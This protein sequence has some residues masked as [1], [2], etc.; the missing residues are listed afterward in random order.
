[1]KSKLFIIF[2]L[3][4]TIL[5]GTLVS[6]IQSEK[7]AQIVK[8]YAFQKIPESYGI[9]GDFSDF[10][11]KLFPPGVS[12]RNPKVTLEK[13]NILNFPENS[14]VEAKKVDLNFYPLQMISG[15]INVHEVVISGGNV[16]LSIH[17]DQL[18]SQKRKKEEKKQI[19][20]Q[21][22]FEVKLESV[23]LEGTSVHFNWLEPNIKSEFHSEYLK[24][25]K[26]DTDDGPG[27]VFDLDL[28]KIEAD[29]P[30]NWD[31]PNSVK[32]LKAFLEIS[33]KKV[34]IYNVS[35]TLEDILIQSRGH[36]Y[37]NVLGQKNLDLDV[38]I[39]MSGN[40]RKITEMFNV[41]ENLAGIALFK[42]KAKGN[43]F[44]L[45][46]TFFFSGEVE[47]TGVR[48]NQWET[49]KL[50]AKGE[51]KLSDKMIDVKEA[52]FESNHR[53]RKGGFQTGLGG[54][55]DFNSFQIRTGQLE[56]IKVPI[57]LT[58]AHLH[59][60]AAP[61]IVDVFPM[62]VRLS[63]SVLVE[64]NNFFSKKDWSVVSY[65]D[66]DIKNFILDNQKYQKNK[67]IS[68]ILN[69]PELKLK[70]GAEFNKNGFYPKELKIVMPNTEL[71]VGGSVT[72]KNG[73]DLKAN[74]NV[75]FADFDTLAKNKIRGVGPLQIHVHG[76]TYKV[77]LDFDTNLQNTSYL[78]L[79]IGELIGR[80]TF[81]DS[82]QNLIFND[83]KVR[84]NKLFMDIGGRLNV[85]AQDFADLKVKS[86]SGEVNDLIKMFN[87]LVKDIDWFPESLSGFIRGEAVVTGQLGMDQIAIIGKFTGSNWDFYGEKFRELNFAGGY[88]QGK[89]FLQNAIVQKR[90]GYF[91]GD[92]S[93]SE[94]KGVDWKLKTHLLSMID[95]DYIARLDVPMRGSIQINTEGL[96]ALDK[97]KSQTSVEFNNIV[98]RGVPFASSILK[99]DSDK[100]SADIVSQING[101]Q[102]SINAKY[103][104]NE[105]KV[106]EIHANFNQL[107]FTPLILL[108]NPSLIKDPTLRGSFSLD[109]NLEF[110]TN[111]FE[112][113]TGEIVF[114]DYLIKKEGAILYLKEPKTLKIQN[115]SYPETELLAV[116]DESEISFVSSAKQSEL[117]GRLSGKVDLSLFEFLSPVIQKAEGYLEA[118]VNLKGNLKEPVLTGEFEFSNGNL[119]LDGLENPFENISGDIK[120]VKNSLLVQSIEA[121][122]GGG[123]VFTSGKIDFFINHFPEINLSAFVKQSKVKIYPFSTVDVS[124]TLAVTGK[125][126]PYLVS[127]DVVI[128]S[129]VIKEKLSSANQSIKKASRYHPSS[130]SVAQGERS[131]FN[132]K[133]NAV[134]AGGIVVKNDLFDMNFKSNLQLVNN[135]SVPRLLGNAEMIEGKIHFRG[136][137]FNVDYAKIQFDNPVILN[138][139]FNLNAKTEIKDTKINLFVS[140]RMKKWKAELTS[141]PSLPENEILSLLAIGISSEEAEGLTSE[142]QTALQQGEAASL[143][144]HSLEFNQGV[145]NKTGFDIQVEKSLDSQEGNSLFRPRTEGDVTLSPKLVIK[146][147]IGDKVDLSFGST[148][149]VGNSTE[150][151][152][153]AEVQ[154]TPAVSV[155]GVWNTF[156]G[157]NTQEEQTSF[158]L[159]LKFKKRF[160]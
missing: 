63:G 81:D 97:V 25:S 140:G 133:I 48:F 137:V 36:A 118:D 26:V 127:G 96:G 128:H 149:G 11:I 100:G 69:I 158:G 14:K 84:Q 106:N 10:R 54:R 146:R 88:D 94:L 5:V 59:W 111:R 148:V 68:N 71:S 124:G 22:L 41:K 107:N 62:D 125:T 143:L 159:D 85:G 101:Q 16:E 116:G 136:R 151:E 132:L 86:I 147:N 21:D 18:K 53:E 52:W 74:G 50:F 55:V 40:L 8:K 144:L 135:M 19:E 110:K 160:K 114:K 51:W 92:I 75:D 38:D 17:P 91:E 35:M 102:G 61:A 99:I 66:L 9:K 113:L 108:L 121:R 31:I 150:K 1:M 104:F 129:G 44:D 3:V 42:G 145:K 120:L 2:L 156:E 6:F 73:Y 46:K 93:Y 27:F 45:K 157:V 105:S 30:K 60:L 12:V 87:Y 70:G 90:K 103:H 23:L 117:K 4:S 154:V 139:L 72:G 7:F 58:D 20:W 24:L 138:P 141:D 134:S 33:S 80:I 126:Q 37:G 77:L 130:S 39:L 122:L 82:N 115:G 57:R 123:S 78:N 67:P 112:H 152:V 79:D 95:I 28:N 29:F 65:L 89:Y 98:V 34:R 142:G 13:N 119:K 56:T 109:A 76:P 15:N 131:M 49:S 153:N 32:S 47:G 64:L 43:V 155:I 83:V